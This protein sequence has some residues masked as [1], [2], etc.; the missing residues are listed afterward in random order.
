MRQP[1]TATLL[2]L[3]ALG[4]C[5]PREPAGVDSRPV[6]T[7]LYIRA[8]LTGTTVAT[9]VVEVSASDI[10][11]PLV[12]NISAVNG[13]AAGTIRVSAGSSRAIALRAY[14]AGG[15]GRSEEHTSEIQS[16]TNLVCRLPLANK[17][18]R[19]SNDTKPNVRTDT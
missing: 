12:F 3:V 13:V 5:L 19:S 6:Q 15:V 2:S 4:S 7:T 11:T 1:I 9:V 18:P 17:K 8:V 10:P 14:D 16:L